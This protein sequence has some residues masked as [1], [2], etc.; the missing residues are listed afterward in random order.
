MALAAQLGEL[1]LQRRKL[2]VFAQERVGGGLGAPQL[3]NRLRVG[4][5]RRKRYVPVKQVY[6]IVI[7]L[8]G[9]G[10]AGERVA[11]GLRESVGRRAEPLEIDG[12]YEPNRR[13]VAGRRLILVADAHKPRD[14]IV[15]R[16]LL[17]RHCDWDG[18]GDAA[19]HGRVQQAALFVA[20]EQVARVAA[21]PQLGG[22]VAPHMRQ[23]RAHIGVSQVFGD[24]LPVVRPD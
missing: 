13:A 14:G 22:R 8:I 15:E 7:Q 16:L 20:L 9:R 3:G 12:V 23:A 19:R 11:D 10:A 4:G 24:P 1:G 2:A 17:I 18:I 21:H 6:V 5:A